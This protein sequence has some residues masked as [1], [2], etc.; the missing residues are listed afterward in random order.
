MDNPPWRQSGWNKRF[1]LF[2]LKVL[3][4]VS[5]WQRIS[6]ILVPYWRNWKKHTRICNAV[7]QLNSK[8]KQVRKKYAFRSDGVWWG[9]EKWLRIEESLLLLQRAWFAFEHLH[10]HLLQLE[11]Q[12]VWHS[13]S[14]LPSIRIRAASLYCPP[15]PYP[16]SLKQNWQPVTWDYLGLPITVWGFLLWSTRK[17]VWLLV[18]IDKCVLL[19]KRN[20]CFL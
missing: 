5:L 3:L 1:V 16:P 8:A 19:R 4:M 13:V 9:L 17:G 12:G 7:K 11:F 20:L 6:V 15:P 10:T 2:P 14:H 18:L